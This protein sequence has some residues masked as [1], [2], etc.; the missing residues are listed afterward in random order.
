MRRLSDFFDC[1]IF[2]ILAPRAKI[3]AILGVFV[4]ERMHFSARKVMCARAHRGV[5]DLAAESR[6]F[7]NVSPLTSR[8]PV[9]FDLLK[10]LTL[11]WELLVI[12][13]TRVGA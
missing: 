6:N 12:A 5:G 7:H 1:S 10:T 11:F 8:A 2:A 9:S 4:L 3:F 13:P